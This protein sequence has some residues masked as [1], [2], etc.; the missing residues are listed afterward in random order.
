MSFIRI[1]K[2]EMWSKVQIL[3]FTRLCFNLEQTG[4]NFA[5]NGNTLSKNTYFHFQ[6]YHRFQN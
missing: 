3:D 1:V 6:F 2:C 5:V 4:T